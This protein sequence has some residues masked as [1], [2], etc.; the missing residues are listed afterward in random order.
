MGPASVLTDNGDDRNAVARED[1]EADED[2]EPAVRAVEPTGTRAA[3]NPLR[4][5]RSDRRLPYSLSCPGC[6]RSKTQFA[7]N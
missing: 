6:S 2:R 3:F 1:G 4:N 7:V 5:N